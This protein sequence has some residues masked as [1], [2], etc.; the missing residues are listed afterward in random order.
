MPKNRRITRANR[1]KWGSGL[2][3]YSEVVNRYGRRIKDTTAYRALQPPHHG[4]KDY[5]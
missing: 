4:T 3:L 5:D 2:S 1:K